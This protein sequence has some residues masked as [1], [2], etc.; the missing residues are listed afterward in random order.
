MDQHNPPALK[1]DAL[2]TLRNLVERMEQH[3]SPWGTVMGGEKTGDR[4]FT[5]PTSWWTG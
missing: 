2:Q 5:C 4:T 3:E 1:P